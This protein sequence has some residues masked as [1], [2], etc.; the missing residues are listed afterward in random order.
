MAWTDNLTVAAGETST[1][2]IVGNSNIADAVA[3]N[4]YVSG[5]ANDFI[6]SHGGILRAQA[7]GV[8][9]NAQITGTAQAQEIIEHTGVANDTIV[10]NALGY[11]WQRGTSYRARVSKG[12]QSLVGANARSYDTVVE[13]GEQRLL[14]AGAI[15]YGTII[16]TGKQI[17]YSGTVASNAMVSGGSQVISN[18]GVASGTTYFAGGSGIVSSGATVSDIVISG[19]RF[20]VCD[21]A[22]VGDVT[23]MVGNG[24]NAVLRPEGA[25]AVFSGTI[26]MDL[27]TAVAVTTS[28]HYFISSVSRIAASADANFT[29]KVKED[30]QLGGEY[31]VGGGSTD[32]TATVVT[33]MGQTLGTI[34]CGT[35][36]PAYTQTKYGAFR[37]YTST[38]L[39]LSV[40]T[41]AAV[42]SNTTT[43]AQSG[44]VL[45]DAAVAAG[46]SAYVYADGSALR[47]TLNGNA[48]LRVFGET[49][50]TVV[51]DTAAEIVSSGGITHGTVINANSQYVYA[52][53]S[54]LDTVARGGNLY[55]GQDGS[56]A[57]NVTIHGGTGRLSLSVNGAQVDGNINVDISEIAADN[58]SANS[59]INSL[60]RVL[61]YTPNGVTFTITVAEQDQRAGNYFFGG[62][63]NNFDVT[64]VT[65]GGETLG[66]ISERTGGSYKGE[67]LHTQYG[68]YRFYNATYIMLDVVA[69]HPVELWNGDV[70]ESSGDTLTGQSIDTGKAMYVYPNGAATDNTVNGGV[71]YT[72]NGG[73][74]TGNTVVTGSAVAQSGGILS[75][76]VASGSAAFIRVYNGGRTSRT[77]VRS[78]YEAVSAGAAA[79][80]TVVSGG[81]QLVTGEAFDT[82][83][84][85]G[86]QRI[87]AGGSAERTVAEAG[88]VRVYGNTTSTTLRGAAQE[89]LYAA[90][91]RASE[92]VLSGGTQKLLSA[93]AVAENTVIYGGYQQVVAGASAWNTTIVAGSGGRISLAEGA[94]T[95]GTLTFDLSRGTQ[96]TTAMVNTWLIS[97]GTD[98]CITVA[99]ENQPAG[100]WYLSGGMS[101]YDNESFTVRNT[102]DQT[103]KTDFKVGDSFTIGDF[104][105]SLDIVNNGLY[106]TLRGYPVEIYIGGELTAYGTVV[107]D[108]DIVSGMTAYVY[109]GGTLQ[110][111]TITR[112][113]AG[114]VLVNDG[115]TVAGAA[116]AGRGISTDVIVYGGAVASD[117]LLSDD[118]AFL[119]LSGG[120]GVNTTVSGGQLLMYAGAVA[121]GAELYDSASQKL[122]APGAVASDTMVYSGAYMQVGA[123]EAQTSGG[124]VAG[125]AA[126]GVDVYEEGTVY[127]EGGA[128]ASGVRIHE[129]GYARFYKGA[130]VAVE[131]VAS[132]AEVAV[133]FSEADGNDA[134]IVTDW[135]T[136]AE[137]AKLV[138]GEFGG[139]GT[140]K[141]ADTATGAFSTVDFG[142]NLVLDTR[143]ANADGK[144]SD[145]FIGVNYTFDGKDVTLAKFTVGAQATAATLKNGT[146]TGLADG[147]FAA[148]WD[149]NTTISTVPT[150]ADADTTGNAW[151]IVDGATVDGALYGA[152]GDFAHNVNISFKDGTIKNLAAGAEKGGSVT[153]ANLMVG[154]EKGNGKF[155]GTAYAGGF[156]TVVGNADTLIVNGTFDKDFYA[157]ALANKNA[158][159]T[160]VGEVELTIRGGS[161]KGNLYG[162]SAVKT[163]AT[164]GDGLRHEVGNVSVTIEGGSTTKSDFCLFAGGYATGDATGTVYTVENVTVDISGGSWGTARG[165][166]GIFGG[167]FAS[168]VNAEVTGDVAITVGDGVNADGTVR[169]GDGSMGNIFGGGWAQKGGTSTVGNVNI[170]IAS[171]TVTNIFG[172]G[173]HST[174][175]AGTTVVGNVEIT[176]AG[177]DVTGAIY[178]K[179]QAS[180][181]NVTGTATVNF[182]GKNNFVCDVY[183]YSYVGGV[184]NSDALNF[185]D[186]TGEFSGAIGGF[187]AIKF[188]ASTAMTLAAA[189][190]DVTNTSWK[191][192]V[193]ERFEEQAGT[194]ML[195][196][197]GADFTGDT[198]ALNVAAGSTAEWTLIDAGETTGY[199]QFELLVDGDSQGTLVLDQQ[200]AAGDYAGWGFTLEESVLKFKNLA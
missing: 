106:L 195:T 131:S 65:D 186:Y 116:V 157:G 194:A 58:T 96:A 98:L 92:T 10:D 146:A 177:G 143:I 155:T 181:D 77:I 15:A 97:E 37:L 47:T 132:G 30:D 73:V 48:K 101:G 138:F 25:G 150:I 59:F 24:G 174:A 94:V 78:G 162:A 158:D 164:V 134:A 182:T 87:S 180:G 28:A 19:G 136:V 34:S 21:G 1:G 80:D 42:F 72:S 88:I 90:D 127:V 89:L 129:S 13:G 95:G 111:A 112:A 12:H 151:L 62:N 171:G 183:G 40:V 41:G 99:A 123:T 170:T 66:V 156:G 33:D 141:V 166:R 75:N 27:T 200:L 69:G 39:Y 9:N 161:F 113:G 107:S 55:L 26:T 32:I 188:N 103:L 4:V 56:Y 121:S 44:K 115:G 168:G 118:R 83:V 76:T 64:V 133:R 190:D 60:S 169:P 184:G 86:E 154:D 63:L 108:A 124:Y 70:L 23:I 172:G 35:G 144:F 43:A 178:A 175:S 104:T 193:S 117:T 84:S 82:V 114:K 137:G 109:A 176:V 199:D 145:A 11:M 68:S 16:R 6:I 192:D 130:E 196:W 5:T 147:G 49:Y 67:Y 50:G 18:G 31:C 110:D 20:S 54:A 79:Y 189:A 160:S 38:Y 57:S 74:A 85:A 122:L 148:I 119:R 36:N 71:L 187:D 7:G 185:S 198:I 191:F 126:Y 153:N 100:K 140:Y 173:A 29:I 102:D 81:S 149:G 179:G 53:G 51:N 163:A 3:S 17:V 2:L 61:N 167:I 135:G 128:A 120:R 139:V 22:T 52:G 105:Y 46:Q 165:G 14:S 197:S 91:A 93:G 8:T 125:G 45:E 152:A 159:K 142:E